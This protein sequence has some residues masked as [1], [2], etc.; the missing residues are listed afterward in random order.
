MPRTVTEE[1]NVNQLSVGIYAGQTRRI[2]CVAAIVFPDD[3]W[4]KQWPIKVVALPY[5][6]RVSGR[7]RACKLPATD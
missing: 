7:S 3:R 5:R 6:F 4:S 1:A 2:I